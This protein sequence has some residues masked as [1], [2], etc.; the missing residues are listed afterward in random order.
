MIIEEP[1]RF[2]PA[3][4]VEPIARHV[5]CVSVRG[6]Q[7]IDDSRVGIVSVVGEKRVDC[8]E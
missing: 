5:L 8:F 7:R 6:E 4:E 2:A 1:V 3:R